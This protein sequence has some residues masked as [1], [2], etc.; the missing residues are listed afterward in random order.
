MKN[1][2]HAFAVRGD[3]GSHCN[4]IPCRG[5]LSVARY[6]DEFSII[7]KAPYIR[8]R[9]HQ[10][11]VL[12]IPI[13]QVYTGGIRHNKSRMHDVIYCKLARTGE[14]DGSAIVD[15]NDPTN[16]ETRMDTH[17]TIY[18]QR[19]CRVPCCCKRARDAFGIVRYAT[20]ANP[21]PDRLSEVR[22]ILCGDRNRAITR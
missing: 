11:V 20:A 6:R 21:V 17:R 14:L 5:R 2:A 1:I 18:Q 10:G 3:P 8:V 9:G 7:R 13:G 12:H 22:R 19:K 15:V 16:V 4:I